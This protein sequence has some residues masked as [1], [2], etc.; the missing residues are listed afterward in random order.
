[1]IEPTVSE[2]EK[3]IQSDDDE[4]DEGL[5]EADNTERNITND[6]SKK[7]ELR[8][9][10]KEWDLEILFDYFA[11]ELMMTRNNTM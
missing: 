9:L 8:Q 7:S 2:I 5:C 1:M 10:L 4:R 3:Y 11:G 6:D